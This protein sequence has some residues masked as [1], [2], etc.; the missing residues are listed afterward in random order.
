[1]RALLL[2]IFF[3]LA[4]SSFAQKGITL[5]KGQQFVVK[6]T[7]TQEAD[8]GMGMEM[9]NNSSSQNSFIVLDAD[10]NNYSISSTLTGLKMAIDFMGQSTTYDSDLKSDTA[11]EI[12]KT[13]K[14]L[15]IP[16]TVLVNK[17]TAEVISDK[18]KES[19]EKEEGGNP[20][21]AMFEM[22]GN[23]NSDASVA[24]AFFIIPA[25]MKVG[26]SWTDSSSSKDQKTIRNYTISSIEKNIATVSLISTVTSNIQTEAQGLQVSISMNTKSESEITVD[27]LTSLVSKRSTKADINGT[28]ELM[29]QSAPITGKSV[30]SS[31]YEY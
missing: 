29:G 25:G 10:N 15:F 22:L 18:K 24:D 6:T 13:V 26:S 16:D 8:M 12:G 7:S 27:I 14:N 30:T 17:L 23:S 9:K 4:F 2:P 3:M 5:S 31:V 21:E 19:P 20:M 11:S 1:M 28:L